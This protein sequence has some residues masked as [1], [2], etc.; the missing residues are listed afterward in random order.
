MKSIV[1]GKTGYLY[2]IDSKG[3]LII[4]PDR[5]GENLYEYISLRNN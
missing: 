1:V 3:N 4:H 5:E 2:V